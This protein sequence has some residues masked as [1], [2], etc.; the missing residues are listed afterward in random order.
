MGTLA[1]SALGCHALA[2]L[3]LF[4]GFALSLLAG[5]ALLVGLAL[6]VGVVLV[7]VG[8]VV[9]LV[10]LVAT[11]PALCLL[12]GLALALQLGFDGGIDFVGL[13][14]G[15]YCGLLVGGRQSFRGLYACQGYTS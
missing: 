8:V 6:V 1:Q 5:L 4:L 14:T 12:F 11:S 9:A 13:L 10:V 2:L 7:V 15:G 3:L